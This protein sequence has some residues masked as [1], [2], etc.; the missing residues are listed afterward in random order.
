MYQTDSRPVL[1]FVTTVLERIGE[2]FSY[3]GSGSV[4]LSLILMILAIIAIAVIAIALIL[5]PI[6]LAKRA[7]HSVFEEET[8]TQDI[9][10]AL[11]EAVAAKDWNLAY[12]W[13]YRLMV[14]GLDD[15]EVV[16][17]TPGLTAREAAQAA[18]R[19]VPEHGPALSH[20]ARTFD[21][22]R[23]GHSSVGEQDVSALRDFTPGLLSQCRKAQDHA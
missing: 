4:P 8:T 16:A 22:V 11:D 9:R 14:A 15:C 1:D 5:N 20:H 18:T 7:S 12:V 2:A 17:A 19:L 13:S 21:G 23:Y 10:R 6:R 3:R